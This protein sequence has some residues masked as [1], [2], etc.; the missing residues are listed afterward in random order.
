M[1]NYH[2]R[3]VDRIYAKVQP[4]LKSNA[5]KL[6][7]T[8]GYY[9]GDFDEIWQEMTLLFYTHFGEYYES[10][11]Q[12]LSFLFVC[13]KNKIRNFQRRDYRHAERYTGDP[14]VISYGLGINGYAGEEPDYNGV[15]GQVPDPSNDWK[16]FELLEITEKAKHMMDVQGREIL[17]WLMS[18]D[19]AAKEVGELMHLESVENLTAKERRRVT[20]LVKKKAMFGYTVSEVVSI[21]K[22]TIKPHLE[23]YWT[24]EVKEQSNFGG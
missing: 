14:I 8:T 19:E 12:Y 9:T 1:R 7:N 6:I 24:E 15:W 20:R 21:V 3:A 4:Q 18:G 2:L 17:D 10:D 13:L 5:R 23:K 16:E 22:K 11:K